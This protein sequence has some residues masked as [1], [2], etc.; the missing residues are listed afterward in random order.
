MTRLIFAALTFYL[1]GACGLNA[2]EFALRAIDAQTG[3][4]LS[5]IPITMRYAGTITGSGA[6]IKLHDKFIHRR[7]GK[8]GFAH[9]PEA[10]LL[11][12][13]D[14]VFSLPIT[15]GNGLL[16]CSTKNISQHCNHDIQTAN[17]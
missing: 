17:F 15:Y 1:C 5:G 14:D 3:K 2:Q 12:D 11:K 13:I 4:P 8:D 10:G 7:T 9:F 6:N 16:R